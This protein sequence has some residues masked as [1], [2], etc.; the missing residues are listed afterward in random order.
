MMISRYTAVEPN[1][2]K[3]F[4]FKVISVFVGL[5]FTVVIVGIILTLTGVIHYS[6]SYSSSYDSRTGSYQTTRTGSFGDN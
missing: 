3:P 5:I 6:G 1:M 2:P 4:M